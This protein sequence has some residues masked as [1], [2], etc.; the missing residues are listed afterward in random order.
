M[1]PLL[2]CLCLALAGGAAALPLSS[3]GEQEAQL[4][5][6]YLQA[7]YAQRAGDPQRFELLQRVLAQAPDSAYIKQ[8]LVAEAL[9]A[10][11]PKLAQAYIDFI[12]SAQDDPE[13][14]AVYG[15][16]QWQAQQYPQA[17]KAYEKSL[18]LDQNQHKE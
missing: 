4:F 9:A 2:L 3:Q 12:E 11:T 17:L 16:Y 14:W 5:N 10:D 15:T 18:E 7:V 13:A 6:D 8:Q 1:R